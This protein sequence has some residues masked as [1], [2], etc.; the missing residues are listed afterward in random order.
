MD[1]REIRKLKKE[2][3]VELINEKQIELIS[4]RMNV[5]A[6]KE[7]SLHMLKILKKDIARLQT[8]Y[9]EKQILEVLEK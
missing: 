4:L 3:I 8:I 6:G 9:N 5:N 1:S 2:K 7:T